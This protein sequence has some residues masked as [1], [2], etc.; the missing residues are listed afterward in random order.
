MLK[1]SR[2]SRT[3]FASRHSGLLARKGEALPAATHPL[4]EKVYVDQG[5]SLHRLVDGPL[6][7]SVY[8]TPGEDTSFD[9]NDVPSKPVYTP[10]SRRLT[11]SAPALRAPETN[12]D[13]DESDGDDYGPC[14]TTCGAINAAPSR[15]PR[16]RMGSL[17]Y[18]LSVR[19]SVRQRRLIRMIAAI[20]NQ[21]QQTILAAAVD[22]YLETL[23]KKEMKSCRC[24]KNRLK[25]K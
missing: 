22:Q 21:S 23:G 12:L 17:P 13:T 24:Y 1:G 14:D 5:P 7:P 4:S 9:R 2:M 25:E 18:K 16:Q 8:E 20:R 3:K 6:D 10:P 15:P 19:V 11:T